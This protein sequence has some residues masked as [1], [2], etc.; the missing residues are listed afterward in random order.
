[1]AGTVT[2][3]APVDYTSGK[4]FGKRNKWT[5]VHRAGRSLER[6]CSY[7]NGRNLV[8]HPYSEDEKNQ[9][10]L[11]KDVAKKRK[12]INLSVSLSDAWLTA[13][14]TARTN[15]TTACETP[16]GFITSCLI[17]GLHTEDLMPNLG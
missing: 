13:F 17:K 1:M 12:T 15:G 11:F 3:I 2:Y 10:Q 14:Q 6:N 5:A 16:Q 4:T 9:H 7:G 8:T